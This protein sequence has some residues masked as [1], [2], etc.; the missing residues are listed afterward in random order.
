[1]KLTTRKKHVILAG[2]VVLLGVAVLANWYYTG[3]Q[4]NIMSANGDSQ[5]DVS[6]VDSKNL[7]DAVYVSSTDVD[8]EYF[9]SARLSRD[10]SYD[11]AV[12]T[13]KEIIENN[14]SD[15]QSAKTATDTIS[16]ITQRKIVQS[17]IE[18]LIKAKIGGDCIA[19]ISEDSVEIIV[20]E[21]LLSETV[22]LQIKEIV[23]NNTEI[24]SE[25]ISIIGIK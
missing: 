10:E 19:V 23:M 17:D 7:G 9:A 22:A 15:D 16:A 24:S 3:P 6:N 11:E 18:N 13:L 20:N 5:D 2:L 8:S 25:K 14:E 1:M 12:A 4:T 21:N